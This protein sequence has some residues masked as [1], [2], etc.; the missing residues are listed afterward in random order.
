VLRLFTKLQPRYVI[1]SALI[2]A[3][4]MFTSAIV[5]LRENRKDLFHLLHEHS[6]SLSETITNSSTNIVLSTD[7]IEQQLS[8]RLFN[9]AMFIARLDSLGQLTQ[10]DLRSIALTNNIF[11]INIF[12][13][14]GVRVLSNHPSEE[15]RQLIKERHSPMDFLRPIFS[16]EKEYIII[17][18]KQARFEQGQRYAVAVR[19]TRP[20]GGAIVL[21]L[22]AVDLVEFRKSIGIGKLINDLG[23]NDGIEYVVLQDQEGILAATN[24]VSEM[25]SIHNDAMLATVLEHDTVM[26]RQTEFDSREVYEVVQRL[27]I[28]N[29]TVGVLRIG[30]SMDEIRKVDQRMQR[31]LLMMSIV[32]TG[33]T[34]LIGA[35]LVAAKNYHIVSKKFER[36]QMFTGKILERM[37]DAVV[38]VDENN[39]VT[40][41]NTQA[42]A[43]FGFQA[44]NVL[45][46]RLPDLRADSLDCLVGILSDERTQFET[47]VNC[48]RRSGDERI[49][50]VT[51]SVTLQSDGTLE[52]TTVV[53]KDLTDIKRLEKEMQRKDKLTA[54]GELASGVAHEIRNP[55]NAISMIAQRF[56]KEFSPKKGVREYK[57]LANVLKR[58]STRIN[59]II[60]QFLKF[61]RPKPI[62]Y[63][64][65]SAA[66]FVRQ[67]SALFR[68]QASE[69][70]ITFSVTAAEKEL[71]IDVEQMTQAILNLL[72]NALDATPAH[73]AITLLLRTEDHKTVIDV[74]DSGSGISEDLRERIFNLYFTTKSTGTGLG[75]SITQQ[76]V[77]QHNGTIAFCSG[78]NGGTVFTIIIPE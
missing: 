22:D 64:T 33:L 63:S 59:R 21:N 13:K 62:Q 46:N 61:A 72:Q 2:V 68:S 77:A 14:H 20:G 57:E 71:S 49:V 73:G 30:L 32:F 19:R 26:T 43:L 56:E 34:V 74:I 6:L 5:E 40:I 25:S 18:L 45:G 35:F 9:N 17:G 11:R 15:H 69:K 55:L 48:V 12:S 47:T 76:I 67:I 28:E 51:K 41:F 1:I 8:E 10:T 29:A 75:L 70:K 4:I 53:L 16:G 23:N 3:A 36:Y 31:R 38:T 24:V 58:E 60:Q 42:E 27:T 52:S 66:E 7:Q 54:M 44:K 39:V 78:E 50:A 65:I 37:R